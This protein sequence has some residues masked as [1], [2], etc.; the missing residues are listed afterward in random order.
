LALLGS[1]EAGV[2][3][4]REVMIVKASSKKSQLIFPITICMVLIFAFATLIQT[5][6]HDGLPANEVTISQIVSKP[7][8]WENRTV[9]VEGIV[10]EMPRGILQPFNYWL[11]ER[12]NQTTRIGLRWHSSTSLSMRNVTII[13][14]IRRGY[15]WVHPDYSGWWTYYIEAASIF[16]H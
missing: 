10:E 8:D 14:V 7:A 11:S 9:K 5:F 16:L 4:E 2:Y 12:Q 3:V 6:L 13:G 15:A 1:L